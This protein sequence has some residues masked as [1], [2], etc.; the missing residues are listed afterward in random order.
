[1]SQKSNHTSRQQSLNRSLTARIAVVNHSFST[2]VFPDHSDKWTSVPNRRTM[3]GIH[4]GRFHVTTKS[5]RGSITTCVLSELFGGVTALFIVYAL[6]YP[7]LTSSYTMVVLAWLDT[8]ICLLILC[9]AV[10]KE[11]I[12]RRYHGG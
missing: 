3:N 7:R 5:N 10:C 8:I 4:L 1:M 2:I 6:S 9:L 11:D 12:S